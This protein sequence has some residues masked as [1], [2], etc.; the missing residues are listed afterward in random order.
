[1]HTLIPGLEQK[2]VHMAA[3]AMC[4]PAA[5]AADWSMHA[6]PEQLLEQLLASD[7]GPPRP[8]AVSPALQR[9]A[10]VAAQ[11]AC[12]REMRAAPPEGQALMI[13]TAQAVVG[14]AAHAAV[15]MRRAEAAPMAAASP[16]QPERPAG[17]PPTSAAQHG[18]P[19]LDLRPSAV[20]SPCSSA[21]LSLPG[22]LPFI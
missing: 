8:A 10:E 11:M 18:W 7:V 14:A 19:S 20:A 17:V 16:M 22:L 1:M 9:A 2:M 21:F 6:Q 4:G 15:G 5:N 12:A 13:A 3:A